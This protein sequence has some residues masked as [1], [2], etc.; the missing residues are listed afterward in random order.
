MK[1]I[2]N[3]L[4]ESI[5]PEVLKQLATT[6]HEP[7]TATAMCLTGAFA[8]ILKGIMQRTSGAESTEFIESLVAQ[9][10]QAQGSHAFTAKPEEML[11][12]LEGKSEFAQGSYQMLT[13][14]FG[15]NLDSGLSCIARTT[16]IK[17]SSAQALFTMAFPM[18]VQHLTKNLEG[19]F[20][21]SGIECYLLPH[22]GAIGA[23]LD[24]EVGKLI[25]AESKETPSSFTRWLKWLV[26]ALLLGAAFFGWKYYSQNGPAPVALSTWAHLGEMEPIVLPGKT[27]IE[28][29]KL[30]IE[31]RLVAFLNDKTLTL[32]DAEWLSFDRILFDLDKS[33]LQ[34]ISVAQLEVLVAILKAYPDVHLEIGGYTDNSGTTE[35]N[36]ALSQER[37]N[38]VRQKLIELGVAGDR[39]D[40]AKGY[41]EEH[42]VF[43]NDTDENRAKNRRVDI[44]VTKK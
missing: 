23:S 9:I 38:S 3:D 18:V 32:D 1:N 20:S 16:G 11:S 7:E 40:E 25:C 5:S 8:A 22:K 14:L 36:M 6:L 37:A 15:T 43:P 27:V 28:A 19:Q 44:K 34:P 33:T 29:P 41:G 42:P 21:V 12:L 30:G 17:E 2:I 35:H 26:L 24:P 4:H 13:S 39:I 10:K 31:H